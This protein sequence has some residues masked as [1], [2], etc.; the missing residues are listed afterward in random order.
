MAESRS[1]LL[2]E[3]SEWAVLTKMCESFQ[4]STKEGCGHLRV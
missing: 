4:V 1:E 3:R 2:R